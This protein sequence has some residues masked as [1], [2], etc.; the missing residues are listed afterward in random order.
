LDLNRRLRPIHIEIISHDLDLPP[1][2]VSVQYI[3]DPPGEHCAS[4]I[5]NRLVVLRV[6]V[7]SQNN[8]LPKKQLMRVSLVHLSP[9]YG[10]AA[11]VR[12]GERGLHPAAGTSQR[13]SRSRSEPLPH[14]ALVGGLTVL[15]HQ[16]TATPIPF[17]FQSLA[18]MAGTC[19]ALDSTPKKIRI[20][21]AHP[22]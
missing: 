6:N 18:V 16:G 17:I 21:G 20:H 22:Q 8:L 12:F 3:S 14:A 19:P 4:P 15:G 1:F 9:V 5:G 10:S 11:I 7:E 13:S 2:S